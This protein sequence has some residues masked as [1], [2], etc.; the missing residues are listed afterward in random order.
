MHQDIG[1]G[2]SLAASDTSPDDFQRAVAAA[3]TASSRMLAL[4]TTQT[5]LTPEIVE[6]LDQRFAA[7]LDDGT[8]FILPRSWRSLLTFGEEDRT[9]AVL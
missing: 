9:D 6:R 2:A 4:A 7:G 8:S 3:L 5:A 1:I